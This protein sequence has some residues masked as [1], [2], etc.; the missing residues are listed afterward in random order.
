M[1]KLRIL[2]VP[3]PECVTRLLEEHSHLLAMLSRLSSSTKENHLYTTEINASNSSSSNVKY[4]QHAL[5]AIENF[6]S[7]LHR[8]FESSGSFW[9]GAVDQ[10]WSFGPN[11][12]GC[13]ILLNRIPSYSRLS[14]W[15][16]SCTSQ[17]IN[18]LAGYDTNFVTGFQMA[19]SAGPLCEEPMMGVC[20]VIEEWSMCDSTSL[21]N[22]MGHVISNTKDALRKAFENSHQRLMCAMYSCVVSVTSEVIGRFYNLIGKRHGRVVDGDMTEGSTSWN[23][24]AYIPVI[25]SFNF[26]NELRKCVSIKLLICSIFRV[27][28][29]NCATSCFY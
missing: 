4:S 10:I 27:S 21:L 26:A 15:E 12:N 9:R 1:G 18:S 22:S 3:L 20:F 7:K 13:N 5:N 17:S 28:R 16:R 29:F 8:A 25:E 6:K 11:Y 24:T 2:T 23:V 19:T 14:V